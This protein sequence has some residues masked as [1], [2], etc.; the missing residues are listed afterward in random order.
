MLFSRLCA[1][2]DSLS[3][4]AFDSTQS[5]NSSEFGS[6][7]PFPGEDLLPRSCVYLKIPDT[8]IRFPL[9]DSRH[10]SCVL[11]PRCCCLYAHSIRPTFLPRRTLL[12]WA[13]RPFR[14]LHRSGVCLNF[15]SF[16]PNSTKPH[17]LRYLHERFPSATMALHPPPPVAMNVSSHAPPPPSR[18]GSRTTDPARVH[19]GPGQACRTKERREESRPG[20]CRVGRR[21]K[22]PRRRGSPVVRR[23]G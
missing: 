15:L 16:L 7:S 20:S 12:T 11:L 17:P 5:Q 23:R 10:L 13:S 3:L 18:S 9:Q 19:P 8:I 6:S 21:N 1:A 2:F 4:A 14:F 22:K